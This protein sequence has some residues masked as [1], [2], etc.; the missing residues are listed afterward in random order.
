VLLLKTVINIQFLINTVHIFCLIWASQQ[1]E[2]LG[3][4]KTVIV[5]HHTEIW[6]LPGSS[7]VVNC[8]TM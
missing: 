2:E 5:M 1:R 7:S 8:R 3:F 6:Y 4:L